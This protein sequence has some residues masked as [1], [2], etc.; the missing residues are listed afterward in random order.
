MAYDVR[1]THCEDY[2]RAVIAGERKEA[3][4]AQDAEQAIHTITQA[5]RE[6][7]VRKVLCLAGLKGPLSVGAAYQIAKFLSHTEF[8][9][10]FRLAVVYT[11]NEAETASTFG[12]LAAKNR[13]VHARV[14]PAEEEALFWLR[15]D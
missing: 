7:Q 15:A 1:V 14:F 10:N 13:G 4:A 2:V 8:G 11:Y 9:R 6:A 3:R 12:E 5:C